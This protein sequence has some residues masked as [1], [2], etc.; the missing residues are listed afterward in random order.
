MTIFIEEE[1][2]TARNNTCMRFMQKLK[3]PKDQ[4][5]ITPD[6]GLD[7]DDGLGKGSF[8][9]LQGA[10]VSLYDFRCQL[11]L[12]KC[13]LVVAKNG[14]GAP[15]ICE[16][17]ADFPQSCICRKDR[18]FRSGDC[19][20]QRCHC[21]PDNLCNWQHLRLCNGV[22][23]GRA[24]VDDSEDE[25]LKRQRGFPFGGL[26]RL[27]FLF[28]SLSKWKQDGQESHRGR[29][30]RTDCCPSIPPHY[31]RSTQRP[32]L[33]NAVENAHVS[34]SSRNGPHLATACVGSN[35]PTT[36]ATVKPP[37]ELRTRL[38]EDF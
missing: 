19:P 6:V 4:L 10:E 13:D 28:L 37:R 14:H 23:D 29:Y 2:Q 7:C 8:C 3:L 35:P 20:Q 17:R 12:L 1:L 36:L 22:C 27:L 31:A 15:Q 30:P 26:Q 5:Q 25:M 34:E 16:V 9:Q 11:A 33:R 18:V 21:V 32:A 38:R 24:K